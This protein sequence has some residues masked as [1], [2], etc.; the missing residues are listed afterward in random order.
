MRQL[1]K[2]ARP[3]LAVRFATGLLGGSSRDTLPPV[4]RTQ[5]ADLVIQCFAL[6]HMSAKATAVPGTAAADGVAGGGRAW[7]EVLESLH[8]F[9]TVC[10]GGGDVAVCVCVCVC[11]CGCALTTLCRQTNSDY[12]Y[13]RAIEQLVALGFVYEGLLVGDARKCMSSALTKVHHGGA[14]ALIDG[15]CIQLLCSRYAARA[16]AYHGPGRVR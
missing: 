6:A 13:E 11:V 8:Q 14:G 16:A 5:L 2:V 4:D 9:L 1:T 12:T 3:D 10:V 7:Y 15:R